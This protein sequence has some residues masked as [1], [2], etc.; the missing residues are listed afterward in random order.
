MNEGV[1]LLV[2]G[3]KVIEGINLL[4]EKGV[5]IYVSDTSLDNL[6]L[7]NELLF[8]NIIDLSFIIDVMNNSDNVIKI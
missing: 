4:E 3:S 8:G 7:K 5:K 6:N 1:K 2:N